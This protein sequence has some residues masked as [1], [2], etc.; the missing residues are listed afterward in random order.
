MNPTPTPPDGDEE[1]LGPTKIRDLV[2]IAAIVGVAM[3]ILVSD[4]YG[5][6]PSIPL[7]AGIVLYVVAALEVVIALVV[8]SRVAS[9][10]VGRARGQLHPL[11]AARILALAKASAILGAIS[12][13]AWSGMLIFLLGQNDVTQAEHDRAP[14][15][16]ALVG[17]VVL[18]AAALWLEYCCRAPDDPTP[19]ALTDASGA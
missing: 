9:R 5:S 17:G 6:F 10:Q 18:V 15:I 2:V 1:G 13:G 4:N 12:V 7:L 16:V 14:V 11:T 19:D 8:R 3:W